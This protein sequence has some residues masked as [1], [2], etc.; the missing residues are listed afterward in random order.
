M[1][2]RRFTPARSTSKEKDIYK[3]E[4][5]TDRKY[6]DAIQKYKA[7]QATRERSRAQIRKAEQALAARIGEEHALIA[8]VQ[9]QLAEARLNLAYTQTHA[10]CDG[11]ITNLQLREGTHAHIGQAVLTVIDTGRWLIVANFRENALVG[12]RAGQPAR[13]AL[14]AVPGCIYDAQVVSVGGG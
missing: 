2:P 13:V 7:A 14:R 9:A 4:A 10:T 8:E 6:V 5:T 1:P 12:V 11:L 3:Q